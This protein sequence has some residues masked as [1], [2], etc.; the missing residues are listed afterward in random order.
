MA[1]EPED[2]KSVKRTLR[3]PKALLDIQL[4]H[5]SVYSVPARRVNLSFSPV[6][7]FPVL[8]M[9]KA[10]VILAVVAALVLGRTL[11][12]TVPTYA[13]DA[14]SDAERANLE[15]K[16]KDLEAEMQVYQGQIEAYKKQGSSL[17]GEIGKLNA[18]ISQINLQI[19]ESEYKLKEL[20]FQISDNQ[21]RIVK[22]QGDLEVQ[23]KNLG[24]LLRTLYETGQT[25]ILSVFLRSQKFSDFFNDVNSLTSLQDNLR[26]TINQI[27][28]L[29]ADLEDKQ[30]QLAIA[31]SDAET[32]RVFR[33]QQRQ[34]TDKTKLEKNQLLDI[35]KGQE[36]KYQDLLKKTKETAAQI[37]SRIFQLLGGGEMSF[38][39][40]Y[41]LAKMASDATG[42]RAAFVLAILDRESALGQN[43]GRCSYKTAMNPNPKKQSDGTYKSEVDIFLSLVTALNLNP[44]NMMVSCPNADGPYGGAMGPAQ[45][46][47]STWMGY[48]GQIASV[49]GRNPA[50]P[51]NNAD[52]FIA[53]ALY[54][55]DAGAATSEKMAAAKYYCGGRWNRYVCT[56]VYAKKVLDQA[57]QFEDDIATLTQ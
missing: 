18:K 2:F 21:T 47:P 11:A 29:K 22:I 4:P 40:A 27:T 57:D 16:L 3:K 36:S 44:E 51:W 33:E 20:N 7:K 25:N 37:R 32:V 49:T 56:N 43:V 38:G 55:R 9:L 45:F 12:P 6:R 31:K 54:L 53:S 42:V 34:E 39:D 30:T 19:K 5:Q 52:A 15:A 46:I 50:N 1:N 41:K 8:E 13:A 26:T 24:A 10:G 48:S 17:K 23:K 35:T 14:A 28:D